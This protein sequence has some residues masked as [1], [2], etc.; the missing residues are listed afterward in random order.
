MCG[1]CLFVDRT[2]HSQS[3][4]GSWVR[5]QTVREEQEGREASDRTRLVQH[6]GPDAED[7][8]HMSE[9]YVDDQMPGAVQVA[10]C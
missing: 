4:A 6:F 8:E 5:P 10:R 9:R 2:T 7:V 3:F 1:N